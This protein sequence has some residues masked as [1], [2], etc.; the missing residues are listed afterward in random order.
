MTL[1]QQLHSPGELRAAGPL[2]SHLATPKHEGGSDGAASP[3]PSGPPA[4]LTPHFCPLGNIVEVA[5]CPQPSSHLSA[6]RAHIIYVWS[7]SSCCLLLC[8][9]RRMV[10]YYVWR[11]GRAHLEP[12]LD[13]PVL[14]QGRPKCRGPGNL[15]PQ[16]RWLGSLH[17]REPHH[18][19]GLHRGLGPAAGSPAA[20]LHPV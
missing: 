13:L 4:G 3:L 10:H 19:L 18:G 7:C 20:L 11:L 15:L 8:S 5:W 14:L 2:Q 1:C 12:S 6:A 17:A 16:Q 9:C